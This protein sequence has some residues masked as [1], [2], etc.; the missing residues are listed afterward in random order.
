MKTFGEKF[1]RI[2]QHAD[3]IIDLAERIDDKLISD[4]NEISEYD[5]DKLIS[6]AETISSYMK[7]ITEVHNG[8]SYIQRVVEM[9]N[10]V[11]YVS[12]IR[13]SIGLVAGN[14]NHIKNVS[15]YKD[16]VSAVAAMK[17]MMD[18][19]LA[20]STSMDKLFDM[21]EDIATVLDTAE[22]MDAISSKIHNDMISAKKYS[23]KAEELYDKVSKA[24]NR[25]LKKVSEIDEK[26]SKINNLKII[27][28]HL[29]P[30]EAGYSTYNED[31]SI[32]EIGIPSG[33][34]GPRGKYKGDKGEPG[35]D[36]KDFAPSY[37]GKLFERSR[38]DNYPG[39]ISFL[40]LDEMPT[41]LYF[42]KSDSIGDWTEGQPFGYTE[43][44]D[45]IEVGNSKRL[46]GYTVNEL[47]EHIRKK[48]TGE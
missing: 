24:E 14:I 9:Q 43:G 40:S 12:D 39:G 13:D 31:K 7:T 18:E 34:E 44:F 11:T 42:K 33:K 36:G 4:I 20:M 48:M 5:V 19:T 10:Q 32:L 26:I 1:K 21:E 22:R 23:M 8:M 47:L 45:K 29:S 6:A 30:D 15:E 41:M 38:Y 28:K 37:M 27:V 25:I 3:E 46:G 35:R 16:R 2:A 17:P